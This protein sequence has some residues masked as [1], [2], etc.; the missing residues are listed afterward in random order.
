M[1]RKKL[2]YVVRPQT[3]GMAGHLQTLI[4]HFSREWDIC[5]AAPPAV[6]NSTDGITGGVKYIKLSLPGHVAPLRDAAVLLQLA[7]I[8]RQERASLVHAHGYKAALVALPAARLFGCP[9]LVTVHNSL[10]Y[11]DKSI[12]P[13]S[14]FS[15]FLKRMDFLVARYIA[16]SEA[17]RQELADRGINP[18]KIVTI[19]NGIDTR[20]F[21]VNMPGEK[22]RCRKGEGMPSLLNFSGLKVGTAGRLVFHKG[23]DLFIRAAARVAQHYPDVRFFIAGEGPER[24]KLESLCEIL[25][26]RSKLFFLGHVSRMPVY[27]S[28]LDLYVQPSRSEGLS[29]SLL[30]AGAAGL[31]LIASAVGGIPEIIQHGKTGILVPAED[32]VALEKAIS[33]LISQPESREKLGLGA[34]VDVKSRFAEEKM[35]KETEKVYEEI[36]DGYAKNRTA[37]PV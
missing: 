11:P 16:V 27:L 35:L 12:L 28:S 9:V 33:W 3:G 10:L 34:A 24:A 30:E 32:V 15:R 13:E 23:F 14:Y 25:N 18:E 20:K 2:L 36:V 21:A 19:Y 6:L 17:L 1:I 8:C 7:G 26:M 4:T 31:P 22:A 29:L 37:C 5:I